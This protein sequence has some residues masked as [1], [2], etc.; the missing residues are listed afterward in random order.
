M[1]GHEIPQVEAETR[2]RVGSRYAKR[3][4]EQGKLPAVIYGHGEDPVSVTL[5][6]KKITY[7]VY[8][9]AHVLNVSTEGKAQPCLIK[10]VQWNHLGN[11]IVHLDLTRVSL[12][13]KVEVEVELDLTGEPVGLKT[14]GAMLDQQI[15]ALP[16][17]CRATDIPEVLKQDVSALDVGDIL[18]VSDLKLPEGIV[19]TLEPDAV[20]ASIHVQEEEEI[21]E[22]AAAGDAEPEVI[23]AKPDE[24]EGESEEG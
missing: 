24:E 10:D 8:H 14:A 23:G 22:P 21:E 1:A 6:T 15:T 16:I 2:E 18:H 17:E 5:D 11:Q 19:C 7:L 12:D 13:E 4:R 20:V 3:L 9:H